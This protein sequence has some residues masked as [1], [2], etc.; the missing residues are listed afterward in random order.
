[1]GYW[2][3]YHLLGLMLGLPSVVFFGESVGFACSVTN[4]FFFLDFS[5]NIYFFF[6][7]VEQM[8]NVFFYGVPNFNLRVFLNFF[9]KDKQIKKF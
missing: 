8:K 6:L 1:M 7:K 9:F 3:C 4:F 2:V 5:S